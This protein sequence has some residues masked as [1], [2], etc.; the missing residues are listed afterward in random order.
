[1]G[2]LHFIYSF[3]YIY[4]LRR[5]VSHATH[6]MIS[7][8]LSLSFC[9]CITHH[10]TLDAHV[11]QLRESNQIV[12]QGVALLHADMRRK[13]EKRHAKRLANRKSAYT[14]RARKK[15][16]IEE[17]TRDNARLRR[18]AMILSYLPD[19]VVA[20]RANG[21]ITFCSMQV[22]RVLRH[23]ASGLIGANIE[24]I[25]VPSS[26]ESIRGLIRDLILAEQRAALS[27]PSS[28][29]EDG[30]D[31]EEIG[32]ENNRRMEEGRQGGRGMANNNNNDGSD[33]ENNSA[34]TTAAHE[35]SEPGDSSEQSS[36][37][38][39]LEVN[40]NAG[41][42]SADVAA[43]EDVSDSSGDPPGKKSS[44]S[45]MQK[46][47]Q[48][49]QKRQQVNNNNNSSEMSSLTHKNS[50]LSGVGGESG[51]DGA[52]GSVTMPRQPASLA[53]KV[54]TGSSL[55]TGSSSSDNNG[56]DSSKKNQEN[57]PSTECDDSTSSENKAN[58]NLLKNVEMCKL[59]MDKE[60]DEQVRFSYKDDVMGAFVTANNA[61]A[62]LSSLMHHP[63]KEHGGVSSSIIAANGG[64]GGVDNNN[65]T[66]LV[67]PKEQDHQ[68]QDVGEK[69]EEQSSSADSSSVGKTKK[70]GSGGNSSEDSGYRESNESPEES[71]EYPEDSSSS[72]GE[73]SDR[74]SAKKKREC[75]LDGMLSFAS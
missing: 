7:A 33:R 30:D 29:I 5:P 2:S 51:G 63:R 46:Q 8:L 75:T 47:Q 4:I 42:A 1:M 64:V 28:S 31:E 12:P 43:G 49:Q 55:S 13:E 39:L 21:T 41:Q 68:V 26:R 20:I 58:A 66:L 40:V 70:R 62:K 45:C 25:I 50:S 38:P 56:K 23:D 34:S 22:E 59:K 60:D 44:P 11:R 48:L 69:R 73:S 71:N 19:P 16:L 9:F 3:T 35:V 53:M 15:A 17:M 65:R 32:G 24:D 27:D 10:L 52:T 74:S 18:Q 14:S 67:N 36:F 72:L 54:K 6:I 61:D 57:A 37:P